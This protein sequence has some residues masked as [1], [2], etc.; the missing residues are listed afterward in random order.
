LFSGTRGLSRRTSAGDI[1]RSILE[2]HGV[3]VN[4][5]KVE[6]VRGVSLALEERKIFALMGANGAGKSTILKAIIGLEALSGGK[7]HF[8]GQDV[9]GKTTPEMVRRGIALCP[10]GRRIFPEMSV[11]KNLLSGAYLR[12]NRGEIN[13]QLREIFEY[14]PILSER[15]QQMGGRLSGGE[16]QMLAIGRALM[17]GPRLL[18]LDEPSLGL[19]PLLVQEVGAIIS[20]IL[21]RGVSIILA[22]QNALWSLEVAKYGYVL[23][24]GRISMEGSYESLL[25]NDYIRE[26]YLGG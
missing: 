19:A 21:D 1:V 2:L 10:E 11:L 13:Q 23:E 4:Y 24:N 17:A 18:L 20:N 3:F 9:T 7:I 12:K 16:Q 5:G 6:A 14:F 26:A 8:A 25:G 15:R 22:E